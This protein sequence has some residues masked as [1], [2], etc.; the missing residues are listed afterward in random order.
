MANPD[1]EV[2][3][4]DICAEAIHWLRAAHEMYERSREFRSLGD[5]LDN[6]LECPGD[7]WRALKA[8]ADRAFSSARASEHFFLISLKNARHWLKALA[9]READE[10]EAI[11][12]YMDKIRPALPV[13][14][15]R[16]HAGEYLLPEGK[17][18]RE[19]F[20]FAGS[21]GDGLSFIVDATSDISHGD[22]TLLGG[23]VSKNELF[24]AVCEL[25]PVLEAAHDGF[26]SYHRLNAQGT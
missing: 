8:R 13:R 1:S 11:I 19:G 4:W 26:S 24:A 10:R 14:D 22:D 7:D 25:L 3:S 2:N 9:V 15:F 20:R 5:S 6:V 18:K 21:L 17:P 23:R 12:A 16:E